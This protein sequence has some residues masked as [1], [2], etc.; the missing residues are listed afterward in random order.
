M[1][2][3]FKISNKDTD[4]FACFSF[5]NVNFEQVSV[6]LELHHILIGARFYNKIKFYE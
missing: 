5:F 2:N 3:T 6:G 1:W 4:G